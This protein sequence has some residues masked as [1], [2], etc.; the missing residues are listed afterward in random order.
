MFVPHQRFCI[1]QP[2]QCVIITNVRHH[3]LVTDIARST[4]E[5][6]PFLDLVNSRIEVPA[7][8]KLR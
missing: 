3:E 4:V 5:E 7:D 2:L 6:E 8:W 1:V